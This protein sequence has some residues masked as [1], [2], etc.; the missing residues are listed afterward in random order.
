S[1]HT[2][3]IVV[4][5]KK[6]DLNCGIRLNVIILLINRGLLLIRSLR[7][8]DYSPIF[9]VSLFCLTK[10][11]IMKQFRRISVLAIILISSIIF[12]SD[13]DAQRRHHRNGGGG[14]GGHGSHGG[15]GHRGGDVG[16]PLDGGLLALLAAAGGAYVVG[17][18]KK[19]KNSE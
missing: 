19:K 11:D 10:A 7:I 2:V 9:I 14:H 8:K 15:G 1:A 13:V 12:S 3:K 6:D 18:R 16:A 5:P 4:N 17:R